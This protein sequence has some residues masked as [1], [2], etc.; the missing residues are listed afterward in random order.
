VR[1]RGP[2]H[3]LGRLG[4]LCV[5]TPYGGWSVVFGPSSRSGYVSAAPCT[6][7]PGPLDTAMLNGG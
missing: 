4:D 5:R 7:R 6:D 3:A 1:P 2:Q